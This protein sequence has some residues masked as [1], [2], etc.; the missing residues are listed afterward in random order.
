MNSG[1]LRNGDKSVLPDIC[2]LLCECAMSKPP[3]ILV[4][5]NT[6]RLAGVS[7]KN[8]SSI[9]HYNIYA[10][11]DIM[12]RI[13]QAFENPFNLFKGQKDP[14]TA[15]NVPYKDQT[16]GVVGT[17]NHMGTWYEN[18]SVWKPKFDAL[19]KKLQKQ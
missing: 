19:A 13:G 18:Y 3:I 1:G 6:P 5:L 7:V 10:T 17:Y 8:P 16:E 9:Y 2:R 14:Y 15:V 12:A 4:T 11:N